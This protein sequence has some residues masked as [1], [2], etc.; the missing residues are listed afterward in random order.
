MTRSRRS[1]RITWS[2]CQNHF[3]S[4]LALCEGNSPVTG[5]FP[6]QRPVTRSFDVFFDLRL[7][8]RLSKQQWGWWFETPSWS[9]WR[10]CNAVWSEP[11][12]SRSMCHGTRFA[13][14]FPWTHNPNFVTMF[15]TLILIP[16]SQFTH[17]FAH[18]TTTLLSGNTNNS[19]LSGWLHS[20]KRKVRSCNSWTICYPFMKCVP[21]PLNILLYTVHLLSVP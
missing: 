9:L 21:G 2:G 10:H 16:I 14:R 12:H 3:S 1:F 7:N 11:E 17:K 19:D 6:S 8:K 18:V 20:N 4:F 15:F 13:Y 5:E